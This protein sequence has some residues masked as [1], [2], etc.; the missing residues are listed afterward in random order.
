MN[1]YLGIIILLLVLF[2]IELKNRLNATIQ[3]VVFFIGA[4]SV[5][6]LIAFR[7]TGVGGDTSEYVN[8]FTGKTSMYGTID[9]SDMEIGFVWI[10]KALH[11]VASTKHWLLFSST[12]ITLFPF[13][14]MVKKYSY[15]KTL[16]LLLFMTIWS[17]LPT[18][19]SAMR[20][21]F[22]VSLVM[23]AY[24]LYLNKDTFV[25]D[26]KHRQKKWI[27]CCVLLL[28]LSVFTHTSMIITIP[29]L[30]LAEFVNMRKRTAYLLVI[31]SFSLSLLVNNLFSSLFTI[32]N[33]Y[34][35]AFA[36]ADRMNGY[37]D[38]A[39]YALTNEVSF[40]RLAPTTLW[41]LLLIFKSKEKELN[42]IYL[43]CLI[44][45]NSLFCVGASFPMMSRA[46][47]LLLL[48]GIVYVPYS[49]YDNRKQLSNIILFI[50]VLFFVRT[51]FK[52]FN[53]YNINDNY[54]GV[55]M[56]P[57]KTIFEE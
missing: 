54:Y 41:V 30:L 37:F 8:F 7:G 15:I 1:I 45:G 17:I 51:Q 25:N 43:K 13:Y 22:A 3:N 57:Y 4:L 56:L 29:L 55:R 39:D 23:I 38:N 52:Y 10:S 42:S 6:S 31:V 20:Q 18:S 16:P 49:L 21:N 35:A 53:N 34:T 48:M 50:L 36:Y 12:V 9:N 32:F 44:W 33:E 47:F 26:R 27:L 19:L 28:V 2:V 46:V 14:Y 5:F 11:F 24:I 40:N